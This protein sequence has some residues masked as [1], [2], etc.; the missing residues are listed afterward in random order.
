MARIIDVDFKS[1][2]KI[3]SWDTED[4]WKHYE[5]AGN[6]LMKALTCIAKVN[7]NH[8]YL[9][10]T[11]EYFQQIMVNLYWAIKERKKGTSIPWDK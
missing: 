4:Y 11:K 5:D 7:P 9:S 6:H 10:R 3:S 2:K 8:L 1:K